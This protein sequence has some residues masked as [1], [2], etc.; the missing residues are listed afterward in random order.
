MASLSQLYAQKR[1]VLGNITTTKSGISSVEDKISRLEVAASRLATSI[2]NV[3]TIRSSIS[4]LSI[5]ASRWKGKEESNFQ[6]AYSDYEES[7]KN[8]VSRTEDAKDAIDQ[9]IRRYELERMNL[10]TELNSLETRLYS[11][12][13][14]IIQAQKERDD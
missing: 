4:K 2:S 14:Q 13:R 8:Y 12:E 7:V 6:K 10:I 5:D 11:I 3:E 9:D 1:T